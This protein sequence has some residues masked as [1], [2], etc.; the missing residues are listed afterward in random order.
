MI[1]NCGL[2]QPKETGS[3]STHVG[4]HSPKLERISLTLNLEA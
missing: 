1:A 4:I 3:H 2:T